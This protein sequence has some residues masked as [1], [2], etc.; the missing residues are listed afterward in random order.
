MMAI[1]LEEKYKG[2]LHKI[3]KMIQETQGEVD[4]FV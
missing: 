3:S 1:S 4:C 2:C